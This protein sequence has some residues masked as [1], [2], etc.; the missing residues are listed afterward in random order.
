MEDPGTLWALSISPTLSRPVRP[1]P[2]PS[3]QLGRGHFPGWAVAT[4]CPAGTH[5]Q[6]VALELGAEVGG[7]EEACPLG[8]GPLAAASCVVPGWGPSPPR[9]RGA[10]HGAGPQEGGEEW[11][12]LGEG[13]LR[14]C[15][16]QSRG[17]ADTCFQVRLGLGKSGTTAPHF[18]NEET[19]AQRREGR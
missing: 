17:R 4:P 16:R 7:T 14:V 2:L 1:P 12:R 9:D 3:Q 18:A 8:E 10:F 5:S 6:S 15:R 11:S 13:C 19:E